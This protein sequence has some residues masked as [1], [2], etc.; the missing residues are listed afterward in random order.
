MTPSISEQIAEL[1]K[2]VLKATEAFEYAQSIRDLNLKFYED[3]L[4]RVTSELNILKM[5]RPV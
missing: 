1:E 5:K 2:Q 4:V 3:E